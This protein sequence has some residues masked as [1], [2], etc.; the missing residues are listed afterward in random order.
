VLLAL[1]ATL[2]AGCSF[3]SAATSGGRPATHPPAATYPAAWRYHHSGFYTTMTSPVIELAAV[4]TGAALG[5]LTYALG[6]HGH[7]PSLV[8]DVVSRAGAMLIGP[9]VASILDAAISM[10][11]NIGV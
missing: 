2:P 9:L 7:S 10:Y 8:L 11:R 6:L 3:G 5:M 4:L 1:A